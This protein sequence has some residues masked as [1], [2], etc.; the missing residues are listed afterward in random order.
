[1]PIDASVG[2]RHTILFAE[3][4][5]RVRDAVVFLLEAY[6]FTL[7][8]ARDGH[9]ALRLLVDNH[10]DV[11]FTDIVMP[12]MSGFELAAQAKLIRPHLAV[13][14]M[15]GYAE[16][17]AG[18]D[19]VRYGKILEKPFRPAQLIAELRDMLSL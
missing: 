18:Y 17:A 7:L 16:R 6:G 14:Y 8:V 2:R 19:G 9:E 13:L 1:M 3:D 10:V 15:T 5:A 11:L 12:G 4:D